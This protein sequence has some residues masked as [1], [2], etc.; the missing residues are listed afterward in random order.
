MRDKTMN[1]ETQKKNQ[2]VIKPKSMD[3][4]LGD[5]GVFTKC[6]DI[7]TDINKPED[8]ESQRKLLCPSVEC[9][10]PMQ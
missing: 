10:I 5:P 2:I 3:I 4:L 9:P 1:K 7:L 8:M 6:S